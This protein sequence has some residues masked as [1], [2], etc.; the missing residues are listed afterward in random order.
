M[1]KLARFRIAPRGLAA[2]G[3]SAHPAHDNLT[4]GGVSARF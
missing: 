3:L 1:Q 2:A 4:T